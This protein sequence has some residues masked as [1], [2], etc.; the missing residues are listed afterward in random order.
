MFKTLFLAFI[1]ALLVSYHQKINVTKDGNEQGNPLLDSL[2]S[3]LPTIAD[4]SNIPALW[5]PLL[6]IKGPFLKKGLA[7]AT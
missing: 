2:T 4:K 5:W 6:M 1:G 7:I 3:E